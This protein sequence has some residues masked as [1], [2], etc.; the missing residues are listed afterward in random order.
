ACVAPVAAVLA[1]ALLAHAWL[2]VA[3]A[4]LAVLLDAVLL[5]PV[6]I[7]VALA[8]RWRWQPWLACACLALLLVAGSAWKL[9]MLGA[10]L[11]AMDLFEGLALLQVLP[12]WRLA[13]AIGL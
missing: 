8:G 7:G 6:S 1:C 11:D 13:V 10:P 12:G 3:Y 5:L 2:G 4:P 9:A